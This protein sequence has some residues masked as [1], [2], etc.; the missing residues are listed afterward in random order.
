MPTYPY[1]QTGT[2]E[3]GLPIYGAVRDTGGTIYYGEPDNRSQKY[4]LERNV[5]ERGNQFALYEIADF[6]SGDDVNISPTT[7]VAFAPLQSKNFLVT[8]I[9]VILGG[10]AVRMLWKK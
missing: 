4:S 1:G 2:T 6:I 5:A 9:A 3:G 8:L 10:L 7:N